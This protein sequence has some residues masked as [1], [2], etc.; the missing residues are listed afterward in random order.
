MTLQ[1]VSL[2]I[3]GVVLVALFRVLR[4]GHIREK[5]AALWI[6]VGTAVIA[7]AVFPDLL[8]FLARLTGVQVAS[9]LL[10]FLAILL[11]LGVSLHLSLEASKL[12]D[13]VRVLAE[14][15]ALLWHRVGGLEHPA[16]LGPAGSEHPEP[17]GHDK[18]GREPSPDGGRTSE[19]SPDAG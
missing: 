5:Y 6:L 12:E 18:A 8:A 7:L 3:V 19:Q 1:V 17:P 14:E 11:L 9:N 2:V 10:F 16:G 13:E 4:S 15:V